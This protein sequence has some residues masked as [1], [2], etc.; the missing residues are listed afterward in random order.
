M[1]WLWMMDWLLFEGL[2]ISVLTAKG[3]SSVIPS[4]GGQRK[5]LDCS[6]QTTFQANKWSKRLG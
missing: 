2:T 4:A 6:Y 3:S 1:E 5:N